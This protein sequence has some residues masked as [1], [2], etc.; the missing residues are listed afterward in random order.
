MGFKLTL[1]TPKVEVNWWPKS[2][3]KLNKIVEDYNRSMWPQEKDPVSLTPWAPRRQPTGTWPILRKTGKMQD[4]ARFKTTSKP[5]IFVV[6][7][8]DYGIFH[9]TGTSKMPQRR[10]LGIGGRILDPMAKVIGETIFKGKLRTTI[11]I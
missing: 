2:K 10:W 6:N 7:S 1:V 9:M 3:N 5:M 8:V 4:S 11:K